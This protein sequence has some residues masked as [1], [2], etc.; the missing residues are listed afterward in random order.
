LYSVDEKSARF[1]VPLPKVKGIS[2]E[3]VSSCCMECCETSLTL[4]QMFSVIKTGAKTKK[5]V[6]FDFAEGM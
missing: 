3:E 6:G 2:E 4:D 1:S 5:K